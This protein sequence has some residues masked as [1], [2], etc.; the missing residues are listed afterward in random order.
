M[1]TL[2]VNNL[3][4]AYGKNVVV[5]NVSFSLDQGEMLAIIGPNGSGKTTLL[6]S[7]LGIKA[8]HKGS[9]LINGLTPKKA[10]QQFKGDIAYLPQHHNV[11]LLLPLTVFDVVAQIFSSSKIGFAL[12]NDEIEIIESALM[13]VNLLDKKD[14][15]FTSLSGGQR[16]RVLLALAIARKPKLLF[17]DEPTSAL[18]VSSIDQIYK[19]LAELKKENVGIMVISHDISSIVSASD[20][21]GILMNEMKYLGSPSQISE[22]L[23]H[24]TFGAHIKIIPND[25]NCKECKNRLVS[26]S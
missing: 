19:I 26:S 14:E 8:I 7:I 4:L 15:F 10:I 17:L 11:N 5:K 2:E 3:D 24:Q 6:K 25:P 22:D 1:F 21:I 20:K 9:I 23:I 13:R 18:D 16:Q 12:K